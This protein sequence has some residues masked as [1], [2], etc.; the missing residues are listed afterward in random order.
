MGTYKKCRHRGIAERA[1]G[2]I[3]WAETRRSA[4][5]MEQTSKATNFHTKH[6]Q[7]SK[8]CAHDPMRDCGFSVAFFFFFFFFFLHG[9]RTPAP[10]FLVRRFFAV[11][12]IGHLLLFVRN[13][14][15]HAQ[16]Q[17]RR[18]QK[19]SDAPVNRAAYRA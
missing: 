14:C 8:Q 17:L 18:R 6:V 10:Q 5:R 9:P 13:I 7:K 3:I 19:S 4:Q 16:S 12:G 15:T 11:I 1:V 2:D